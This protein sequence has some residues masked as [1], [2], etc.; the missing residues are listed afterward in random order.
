MIEGGWVCRACWR[1]NGPREER[2]Y[3][4]HTPRDQQLAV[5]PGSLK[6]QTEPGTDLWAMERGYISITPLSLDLTD[7]SDLARLA[8]A[9]P[10]DAPQAEEPTEAIEEDE[11][12]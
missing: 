9:L 5:E 6:E 4:C 2:C 12:S 3:R 10:L 8:R 1:P 7:Q 11:S